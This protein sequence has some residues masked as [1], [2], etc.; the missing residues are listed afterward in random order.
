MAN[1]TVTLPVRFLDE[2][3]ELVE[4][5]AVPSRSALIRG[6]VEKCLADLR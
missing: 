6:A 5:G 1:V 2:I 3:D 4:K